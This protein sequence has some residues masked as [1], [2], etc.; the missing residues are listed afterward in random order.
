MSK[1]LS[2]SAIEHFQKHMS[3]VLVC[4]DVV[5]CHIDDVIIFDKDALL[6]V[7]P[8]TPGTSV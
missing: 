2:N 4:L 7:R 6:K 3:E 8:D 5:L 1:E